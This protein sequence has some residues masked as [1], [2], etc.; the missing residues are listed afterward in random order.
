ME[1][2]GGEGGR[3]TNSPENHSG[4]QC[5]IHL[6]SIS[7]HQPLSLVFFPSPP[8]INTSQSPPIE[9]LIPSY[10]KTRSLLSERGWTYS[11]PIALGKQKSGAHHPKAPNVVLMAVASPP[12]GMDR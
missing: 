3:R 1:I 11:Y 10:R 5:F 12:D 7:N 8:T 2:Q 9:N 4:C 6:C